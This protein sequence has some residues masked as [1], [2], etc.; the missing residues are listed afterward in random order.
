M[1]KMTRSKVRNAFLYNL[2][3]GEIEV[4]EFNG[5]NRRVTNLSGMRSLGR[6]S[7]SIDSAT[8]KAESA[9]KN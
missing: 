8:E 1:H 9:A 5:K 2:P 4:A 3:L 6:V 7:V